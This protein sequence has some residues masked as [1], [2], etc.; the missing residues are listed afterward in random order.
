MTQDVIESCV[1]ITRV[2]TSLAYQHEILIDILLYI[3]IIILL[4]YLWKYFRYEIKKKS[5][6]MTDRALF[7]EY[8]E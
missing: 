2:N 1:S 5:L 4:V 8:P 3:I 7:S 6:Q